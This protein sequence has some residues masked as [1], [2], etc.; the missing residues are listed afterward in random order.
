MNSYEK[1]RQEIHLHIIY[2]LKFILI[3]NNEKHVVTITTGTFIVC[4]MGKYLKEKSICE[5]INR[6]VYIRDTRVQYAIRYN[7]S[8]SDF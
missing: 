3:A 5:C 2:Q 7:P 1:S 6:E 8:V 4:N